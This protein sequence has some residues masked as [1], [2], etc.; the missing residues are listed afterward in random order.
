LESALS[1]ANSHGISYVIVD[2]GIT[3]VVGKRTAQQT[4]VEAVAAPVTQK[5]ERIR[6]AA[7]ESPE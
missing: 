1:S 3:G 2:S 4:S 5:S 7:S 6:A